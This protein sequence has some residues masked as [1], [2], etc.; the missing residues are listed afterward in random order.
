M[1]YKVFR[2]IEGGERSATWQRE[3][4]EENNI[5]CQ[6]KLKKL[7]KGRQEKSKYRTFPLSFGL[8]PVPLLCIVRL[9]YALNKPPQW[10]K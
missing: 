6:T 1:A 7:F 3:Q 5:D 9:P 4:R 10:Q 2:K 8:I